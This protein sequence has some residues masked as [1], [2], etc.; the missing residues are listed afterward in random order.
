MRDRHLNKELRLSLRLLC[1]VTEPQRI[2][3]Q[4]PIKMS[5]LLQN[6]VSFE[7]NRV[8]LIRF[9]YLRNVENMYET[10][11]SFLARY[12]SAYKFASRR[13]SG[14]WVSSTSLHGIVVKNWRFFGVGKVWEK[15]CS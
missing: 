13:R 14:Y 10:G 2:Q 3:D 11:Q 8:W 12:A 6:T 4:K 7:A 1:P 9:G 15:I 5:P